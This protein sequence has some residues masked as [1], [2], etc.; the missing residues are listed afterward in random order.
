M[1]AKR[2]DLP[3][4][5]IL[6][7][8]GQCDVSLTDQDVRFLPHTLYVCTW[9]PVQFLVLCCTLLY[10]VWFHVSVIIILPPAIFGPVY[11]H[12]AICT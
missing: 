5:R 6:L 1:A 8:S 2:G 11:I 7:E 9:Q 10:R 12:L 4:V 3:T